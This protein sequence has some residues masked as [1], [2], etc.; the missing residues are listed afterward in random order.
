MLVS[1][2][3][4]LLPLD[5]MLEIDFIGIEESEVNKETFD[6]AY[7]YFASDYQLTNPLTKEKGMI[8]Y[9]NKLN[10]YEYID[11][12][13]RKDLIADVNDFK[14]SNN[15]MEIFLK[16]K[17]KNHEEHRNIKLDKINELHNMENR[18]S[19]ML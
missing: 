17:N 11:E 19:E 16:R 4:V 8:N 6:E 14:K 3:F 7:F 12:E 10:K 2:V 5:K 18:R 9:I 13:E 15:L 1:C